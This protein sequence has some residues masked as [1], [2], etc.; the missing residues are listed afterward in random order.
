MKLFA[1]IF[2]LLFVCALSDHA[3]SQLAG[4]YFNNGRDHKYSLDLG[5]DST[6]NFRKQFFE[7]DSKCTGKWQRV[8]ND[9]IILKCSE[10]TLDEKLQYGYMNQRKIYVLILSRSRLKVGTVIMRKQ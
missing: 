2:I 7:V 5:P 8:S 6:F 3:F 9:T 10:S 1:S 4:H